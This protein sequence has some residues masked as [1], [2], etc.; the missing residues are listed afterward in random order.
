MYKYKLLPESM[1]EELQTL[2]SKALNQLL[3]EAEYKDSVNKSS[4][5]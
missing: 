1:I 4:E 3:K 5:D 2:D